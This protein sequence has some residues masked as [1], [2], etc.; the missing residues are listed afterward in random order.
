[1]ANGDYFPREGKVTFTGHNHSRPAADIPA[2]RTTDE[3]N[4]V[5]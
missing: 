5:F 2:T 4:E 3:D 1:V